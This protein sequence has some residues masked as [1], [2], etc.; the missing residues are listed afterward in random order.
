MG[1][2]SS[3]PE[4][5]ICTFG[6][7]VCHFHFICSSLRYVLLG[8][9]LVEVETNDNNMYLESQTAGRSKGQRRDVESEFQSLGHG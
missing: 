2:A 3:P 7:D 4:V 1:V 8:I 5:I 6:R 9:F